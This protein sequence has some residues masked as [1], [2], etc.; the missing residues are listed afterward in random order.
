MS[1]SGEG[2]VRHAGGGLVTCHATCFRWYKISLAGKGKGRWSFILLKKTTG[3]AHADHSERH[4][5][6]DYFLRHS[7]LRGHAGHATRR[8]LVASTRCLASLAF[9]DPD[10]WFIVCARARGDD[11]RFGL[12]LVDCWR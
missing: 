4:P 9:V 11:V 1:L 5:D 3:A 7:A 6:A 2:T 10:M 8:R 12:L